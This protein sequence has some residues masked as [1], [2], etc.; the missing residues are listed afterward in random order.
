MT[1]R[2]SRARAALAAKKTKRWVLKKLRF[3]KIVLF[4]SV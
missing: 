3:E 2:A 4:M 1:E